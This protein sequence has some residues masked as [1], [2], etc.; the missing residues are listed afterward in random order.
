MLAAGA[1]V[2]R[3]ASGRLETLLVHRPRYDDWTF[4]KGKLDPGEC[5]PVAAVRETTEETGVPVR[6]GLPLATLEYE[7]ST[8]GRKRVSYWFARPCKSGEL[9]YEANDEIDSLR[10]VDFAESASVLS[11][12]N[13]QRML[14]GFMAEVAAVHHHT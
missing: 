4:P 13:D 10:C 1:I 7:L 9:A 5:L 8:G 6:L 11:Y 3:E 2:W 14:N 12:D